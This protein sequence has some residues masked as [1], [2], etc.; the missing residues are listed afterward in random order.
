MNKGLLILLTAIALVF[1]SCNSS[2]TKEALNGTHKV[3]VKEVLQANVYTYLNVTEDG[4]DQWIAVTKINAQVGETYYFDEYMEM[5][6]FESKDLGRTFESVYFV[7][8]LRKTL[9][10][11]QAHQQMPEGHMSFQEHGG[12]PKIGRAEIKIE[13][14]KGGITIEELFANR[15]KYSGKKVIV[16]GKVVKANFEIMNKNWF[17]IQDGTSSEGQFDLTLTSLENDVKVGDVITFE[18]KVAL[19]KDFGHGYK[20]DIL[21]EESV[22]K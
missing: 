18:G 6:L 16:K 20:Y 3:V 4:K 11:M 7:E 5:L 2:N 12:K 14:A 1:S 17:H 15:E 8:D 13:P 21:L 10:K 9:E 19:N 22:K